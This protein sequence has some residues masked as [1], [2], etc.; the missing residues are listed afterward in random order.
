MRNKVVTFGEILGRLTPGGGLRLIQACPGAF[1]LAPAGSE[2]NVAVSIALLGGQAEFVSALPDH[3]VARA[4][5]ANI[6]GLGVDTSHVVLTDSGRLGMFFC[7]PGANQ[8]PSKVIYDRE[9]SAFSAVPGDRY[10]WESIFEDAR[11]FHVSGITLALSR[12]ASRAAIDAARAARE[13]GL[14]V[15][16]DLNFRKQLWRWDPEL[17]P[18]RLAQT[19]MRELLASADVLIGNEQ[20]AEDVLGIGVPRLDAPQEPDPADAYREVAAEISR[21]F[22]RL[23]KVAITLRES[24]SASHNRW[25]G[26]LYDCAARQAHFAPWKAGAYRPYPIMPIV[27]RVGAGDAFAAG[28]IFA[29]LAPELQAP[30]AALSFAVAASC[31]AHS[32]V[33]DFNFSTRD[34]VEA[35]MN[36][37]ESG[38]IQR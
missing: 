13:R 5:I 31:L 4:F 8:R 28:L 23:S 10:P 20:D 29:L 11:W 3:A 30:P 24:I 21:Q 32:V 6:R 16:C 34:E 27:D 37:S 35:L 17:P 19:T 38:R 25:G 2:V 26:M 1:Q 14:T 9:G 33:G 7:E 36:G 12:V 22:P 18:R 15:S